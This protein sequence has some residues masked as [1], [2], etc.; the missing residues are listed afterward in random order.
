MLTQSAQGQKETSGKNGKRN[1]RKGSKNKV[2]RLKNQ[3]P[4][5]R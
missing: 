1:W 4:A 3:I 5:G 2:K